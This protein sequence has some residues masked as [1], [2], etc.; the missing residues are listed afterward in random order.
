MG[1]H[2]LPPEA[3]ENFFH[4]LMMACRTNPGNR[5]FGDNGFNQKP[6]A[7]GGKTSEAREA[8]TLLSAKRRPHQKSLQKKRQRIM[9]QIRKQE[10]PPGKQP[11]DLEITNL[12]DKDFVD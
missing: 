5:L 4:D 8:T 1:P 7:Q 11:S 2:L 12:H 10:N 9:T 6:R 3:L